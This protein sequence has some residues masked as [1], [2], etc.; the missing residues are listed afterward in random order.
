MAA[1][2]RLIGPPAV[3]RGGRP[4]PSP[5]GNKAWALLAYLVLAERAPERRL[6]AD[7]LFSDANDPLGALRWTLAELRRALQSPELFTGDP[8]DTSLG[9]EIEVDL[10]SIVA[11]R[12]DPAP[13]LDLGTELLSGVNVNVSPAF[14]SWLVVER[15]RLSAAVEARLR[16]AAMT[17]LAA[18]DAA[19]AVAY[20]THAVVRN[21][22]E[23][24]N[25]ELLVRCLAA[26]G[27]RASAL[28]Q[29]AVCEDT[30]RRELG[31]EASVAVREAAGRPPPPPGVPVSGRAAAASLLEAGRAAIVA[32]A[33]TAGIDCLR[34]AA[35]EAACAADPGLQARA[36]SALGSAL[37][38][39]VRGRDDE[40]AIV[41]HEAINLAA[42]AGDRSTAVTANRELG[43]IEL[44][45]G[46]R[47]TAD[48]WLARA[49][50]LAETD[51][52]FAA[53]LGVRGMN[54]SDQG[55]YAAAFDHLTDSVDRAGRCGDDR[56]QAWSLSVLAR[57]HL[58]RDE[59]SQAS[60]ANSRSLELVR[61]QRWMA[62]LPWPQALKSE[63]D[64]RAGRTEVAASELERAWTLAA[65]LGDPCW[66]GMVARGLAL[67]NASSGEHATAAAWLAEAYTRCSQ[68]SDRY[69]W[70][71]A[72]VLD[73]MIDTMI[74]TL[75][76]DRDP[77]RYPLGAASSRPHR[78]TGEL[79]HLRSADYAV[80]SAVPGLD[81][82]G[83]LVEALLS[84]A[85]RCEMRELVV[86]AHVHRWRLGDA[87]AL[88][89]ARLLS[90][91]IDNPVLVDLL[92]PRQDHAGGPMIGEPQ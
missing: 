2:I 86:R 79:A 25:H 87:T 57:A 49:T 39:S 27:D 28:R 31:I 85:A 59:R 63:L 10:Q 23:E 70:V 22:L 16:Q 53:V 60:A 6:L 26:T 88:E 15:F 46:R 4:A 62:F 7:L 36:M 52:E 35:S 92:D 47:R 18:G 13:L 89:S 17:L 34:R 84:L 33:V 55:D 69:Q 19:A 14:E 66:E 1:R 75:V 41:L 42:R 65:Q 76:R 68:V 9:D 30:L 61:D 78:R 74:D 21:P 71:R 50:E 82:V 38:H 5:R 56:Q 81:E 80:R 91:D 77:R 90:A 72:Y 54:A 37:V 11:H 45:A 12:A 67:L 48:T 29:V 64:I 40:G 44:Q 32:G 8:V 58:L 43:F 24:G 20:A 73:T 3:E 51:E 83:A